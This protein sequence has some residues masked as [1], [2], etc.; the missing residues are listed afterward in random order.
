MK[1]AADGDSTD[2]FQF[3]RFR[4][5]AP[6]SAS[7]FRLTRIVLPLRLRF[8]NDKQESVFSD[9]I[10]IKSSYLDRCFRTVSVSINGQDYRSSPIEKLVHRYVSPSSSR[11]YS[12]DSGSFLPVL[13]SDDI[14][15]KQTNHSDTPLL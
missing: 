1:F 10:A 3:L 12:Q 2:D 13:S 8:K 5:D 15:V 11:Q 9:G 14:S 6:S 4:V 7:L